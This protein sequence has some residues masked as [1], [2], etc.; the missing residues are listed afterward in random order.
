M[1]LRTRENIR[2]VA[3]A[4]VGLACLVPAAAKA[5]IGGT[6]P[7][8]TTDPFNFSPSR[9]KLV[10][11][12]HGVTSKPEEAPEEKVGKPG[13]NRHYWGFDFIKNMQGRGLETQ[14]RAVQPNSYGALTMNPYIA[15][16]E[17]APKYS[18]VISTNA[19]IY[20]PA[21]STDIIPIGI[22]TNAS[23]VKDYVTRYTNY[24]MESAMVMVTFRNGS[25]H[26]MPQLGDTID[27]M[28]T[29]Y[30][31]T[32]GH[33]D[34]AKKPQI[35]L[36]THSFGGIVARGILAAPTG[37]DLWG[38]RLTSTQIERAKYLR[39]RVVLVN[40]IAGPHRGAFI[41]DWASD[42]A[43]WVIANGPS[44]CKEFFSTIQATDLV[45]FTEEDVQRMTADFMDT[46]LNAISGT[47][48][49]LQDLVRGDEYNS[50]ILHPTTAKRSNGTY[51]PI[52]TMAGRN[53]GGM[54]YDKSR[55][56]FL[57]SG[58]SQYNPIS[59][60]D[61]ARS[62]KRYAKEATALHII[63]GSLHL[64]GYGKEGRKPWGTAHM[65]EGDK[66]ASPYAGLGAS[67]AKSLASPLPF[68]PVYDVA[69]LGAKFL[70]GEPYKMFKSD[71][72]YDS[73]G[74]LGWD[75]AQAI[76]LNAPNYYRLY[77]AS[78]YGDYLPWDIDNHGSMMFNAGTAAWIHNELVRV[79]GP[80]V[81]T[82]PKRRSVWNTLTNDYQ[83]TPAKNLKIKVLEIHDV[84][85]DIDTWPNGDADFSIR[86]RAGHAE[87]VWNCANNTRTVT[88]VPDLNLTNYPSTVIPIKIDVW[89]RDG[90][91]PVSSPDDLCIVG[92]ENAKS[93]LFLYY[94]TRTNQILGDFK[95]T[96]GDTMAIHPRWDSYNR[97]FLKLR[98]TQ[99]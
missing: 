96:G 99:F 93:S 6:V 20:F 9:P 79:A 59:T 38:N 30:Q 54:V 97:V 98:I 10:V 40:T 88:N 83:T 92:K 49:C 91:D 14:M 19:P 87:W 27:Q 70:A 46:A 85:N 37:A 50:G 66:V 17:W 71:G 89:E 94:D 73:D 80:K 58:S 2:G 69:W 67:S 13:H 60:I 1:K 95:A 33:L 64:W 29:S 18:S 21:A 65:P 8:P 62:G 72:E 4:V 75:S 51:V 47:R 86:V 52:Y 76:G 48:D 74:F 42:L 34:P 7:P 26:L 22:E 61:I 35:Y 11:L 41:G 3:L 25:K 56:V 63:D 28:Y 81:T 55:S 57:L 36:V 31:S 53:P 77:N 43:D 39:D 78:A 16:E 44:L 5:Q 45:D 15:P 23:L 68:N 24:P 84:A 12:I 32:F 90:A 82:T